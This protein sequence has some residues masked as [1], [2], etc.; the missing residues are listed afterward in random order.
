VGYWK[1]DEGSGKTAVDSSGNGNTGTLVNGPKRTT[2]KFS[3]ALSFDGV[4]DYVNIPHKSV[5]NA[6][7]LTVAVW[8]KTASTTG[9]K[10]I[11][12]KYYSNSMN[13]YQVFMNEGNLC[14]WYFKD[15]ADYVWDG[16]GCT[17]MAPG[18]NDNQWHQVV[19]VVDAGGGRLYVD[20]VLKASLGWTGTPGA[21]TTTRNLSIGR[22]PGTGSNWPGIADDV[23]IYNYALSATEVAGLYS[24]ASSGPQGVVW[25]N[26][27]NVTVTGSSLQKTSGCDGCGDAGAVSSQT[28]TS[29]DG[30]VEFTVGETNSFWYGGLSH[31]NPGPSFD[32]INFAF[33][34]N[35]GGQ[36]DVSENGVYKGGS[37]PYA[38]GD[39][40]RVAV[41]GGQVRF[42]KNG[43]L[44]YTSAA[45]PTYPLLLDATLGTISGTVKNAMISP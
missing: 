12:N 41:E 6:Y 31:G 30:Y 3:G 40:F 26:P 34:F 14:A 29:G 38:V 39:V 15:A 17:L 7:P 13:G 19:L 35:G 42:R 16:S 36:A 21:A 11:V 33:R 10:G 2:G 27:V 37:T 22:Y 32:A 8:I 18:Y 43:T 44:I 5:L 20:G 1:F 25:V 28:I 24:A 9:L 23:R 4:N 45:A